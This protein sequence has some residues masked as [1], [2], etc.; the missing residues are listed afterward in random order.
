MGALSIE[1]ERCPTTYGGATGAASSDADRSCPTAGASRAS[2]NEPL[3]EYSRHKGLRTELEGSRAS[4]GL[5]LCWAPGAECG[6]FRH[7]RPDPSRFS[8]ACGDAPGG[9][10]IAGG[11]RERR[12]QSNQ[13]NQVSPQSSSCPTVITAGPSEDLGRFRSRVRRAHYAPTARHTWT[14]ARV[15]DKANRAERPRAACVHIVE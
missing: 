15:Y 5:A 1:A 12:P 10:G 8:S 13:P 7:R 4:A 3:A 9:G 14:Y 6:G 2:L 11:E